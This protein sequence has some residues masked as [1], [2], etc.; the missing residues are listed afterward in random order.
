MR[1]P[2]QRIH[3]YLLDGETE[4]GQLTFAALN[5]QARAIGA[6][7]QTYGA[8][9]ERVLLLYPTGLESIAAFFGCLYAGAI[10]VPA[11]PPNLAQPQRTLLRLRTIANDA[12]PSMA[13]TTS[14]IL[15][16][17]ESLFAQTPELQTM[18]R[19]A[20]DKVAISLARDW[21]DPLP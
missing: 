17:V 21:Q 12:K 19:L 15:S 5:R 14:S 2:E 6:L 18:R 11:P 13:L 9:G 7:L 3:S 1:H 16:R 8:R 20:S 4:G 10:A